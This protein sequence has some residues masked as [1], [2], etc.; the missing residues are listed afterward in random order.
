[1]SGFSGEINCKVD[2]KGRLALPANFKRQMPAEFSTTL[3]MKH[4]IAPCIVLYGMPEWTKLSSRVQ[5]LNPFEPK[6]VRFQRKFM[7]G[8]CELSLD[9]N[10]RINIPAK[11]LAYAG[12][13][14]EAV[15]LGCFDRIEMWNPDK[16]DEFLDM[17]EQEYADLAQEVLGDD[18][19][20][21][22]EDLVQKQTE[23]G[24]A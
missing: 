3:V 14:E 16:L 21:A 7:R 18:S 12:I 19:S 5:S 20:R 6:Q 2:P 9:K 11:A 13:K 15:L 4:G 8:F 1:M 17:E 24:A 22:P 10:N 23:E